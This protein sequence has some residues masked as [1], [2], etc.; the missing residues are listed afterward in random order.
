MLTKAMVACFVVGAK[1]ASEANK[2]SRDWER[3]NMCLTKEFKN[4]KYNPHSYVRRL[5][6]LIYELSNFEGN[7]PS[8]S[9]TTCFMGINDIVGCDNAENEIAQLQYEICENLSF[10]D[11]VADMVATFYKQNKQSHADYLEKNGYPEAMQTM[12]TIHCGQGRLSDACQMKTELKDVPHKYHGE[13]KD[14]ERAFGE[15]KDGG[16][17]TRRSGPPRRRR[18]VTPWWLDIK[19]VVK[20]FDKH[21]RPFGIDKIVEKRIWVTEPSTGTDQPEAAD[22]TNVTSDY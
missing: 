17:L 9:N 4:E 13:Y 11:K 21:R 20:R 16:D 14:Y 15:Y 19:T 3:I 8:A 6:G 10:I 5:K 18:S 12:I 1:A 7:Q 2:V 22:P